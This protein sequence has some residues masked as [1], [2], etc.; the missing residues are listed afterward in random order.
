[1][2]EVAAIGRPSQVA[3]FALV[4]AR[5]LAAR[6]PAEVTAAWRALPE[7]V[8]VVIL[9]EESARAVAAERA[10]AGAPLSVVMPS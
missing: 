7:S 3:G 1:M 4:G 10:G 5:I 9:T 2:T 8:G 6:T